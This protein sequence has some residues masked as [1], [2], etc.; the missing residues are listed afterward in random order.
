[1]VFYSRVSNNSFYY[2]IEERAALFQC[3]V[4]LDEFGQHVVSVVDLDPDP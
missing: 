3:F 4:I 2:Y 1:M